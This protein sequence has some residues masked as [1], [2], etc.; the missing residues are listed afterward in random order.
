[1]AWDSAR[2]GTGEAVPE[3]FAYHAWQDPIRTPMIRDITM[4]IS[5]L[6][7]VVSVGFRRYKNI[8]PGNARGYAYEQAYRVLVCG[9]AGRGECPLQEREEGQL[10]RCR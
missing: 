7:S 2:Q 10:G 6:V 5:V 4:I 9:P 1:M 8:E 3:R